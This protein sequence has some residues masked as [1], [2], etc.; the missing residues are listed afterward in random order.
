MQN[1]QYFQPAPIQSS[2]ETWRFLVSLA[3]LLVI[4]AVVVTALGEPPT[5]IAL[6]VATV[7][8]G[9]GLYVSDAFMR[10]YLG[11]SETE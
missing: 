1:K 5:P 8:A 11:E 3:I 7:F 6:V 10:R 9:I 4:W 2:M